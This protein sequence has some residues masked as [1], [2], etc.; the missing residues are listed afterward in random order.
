[1]SINTVKELREALVNYPDDSKVVIKYWDG[2]SG[3]SVL[4]KDP[5]GSIETTKSKS[6]KDTLPMVELTV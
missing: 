6:S 2:Y 3:H 5:I 4:V 1:M